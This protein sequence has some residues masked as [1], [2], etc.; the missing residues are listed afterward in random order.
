VQ[1][2]ATLAQWF[3]VSASQLPTVF[4]NIGSFAANVLGFG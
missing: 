4:P 1:Y 3:G 2:A